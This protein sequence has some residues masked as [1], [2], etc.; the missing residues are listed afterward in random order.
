MTILG[1]LLWLLGKLP[2]KNTPLSK[3]TQWLSRISFW[4]FHITEAGRPFPVL[5]ASHPHLVIWWLA[6][7]SPWDSHRHFIWSI[8]YVPRMPLSCVLMSFLQETREARGK[9]EVPHN[10]P[11][12]CIA[13]K[14]HSHKVETLGEGEDHE[15]QSGLPNLSDILQSTVIPFNLGLSGRGKVIKMTLDLWASFYTDARQQR[16]MRNEWPCSIEQGLMT[17]LM[18]WPFNIFPRVVVNLKHKII[19]IATS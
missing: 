19:F 5:L 8:K 7:L 6:C 3:S 14:S 10:F 9:S 12:I 1:T 4:Y 2:C 17:F 11:M 18:R 15:T 13:N 16:A